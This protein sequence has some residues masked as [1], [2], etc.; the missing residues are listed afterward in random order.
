MASTLHTHN[1]AFKEKWRKLSQNYH[2]IL[3]LNKSSAIFVQNKKSNLEL[4]IVTEIKTKIVVLNARWQKQH[5][6]IDCSYAPSINCNNFFQSFKEACTSYRKQQK[7][8]KKKKERNITFLSLS[9]LLKHL[10]LWVKFSADGILKYFSYHIFARKQDLTVWHFT[11][12]VSNGDNLHEMKN[13][14]F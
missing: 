4:W 6:K 11:Q 13:P 5:P 8:K 3:L 7:K 10:A 14:V 1:I 9:L 2:Q 12:I